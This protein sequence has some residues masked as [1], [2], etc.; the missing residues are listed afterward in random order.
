MFSVRLEGDT[1]LLLRRLKNLAEIDKKSINASI[2]EGMRES[3]LERF[4]ESRDP[5]GKRWKASIRA[6]TDGGKTLVQTAQLRN[7]IRTKSDASG[8]AVGT[9]VKHAATHQFGDPNR[10]IRARNGKALR[11]KIGDRWISKKKVRVNIP[12][13]PFLG[14]SQDDQREMKTILEEVIGG[15]N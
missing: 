13:R 3:T 8:F 7:S 10:T 12:A 11:F 1:R 15:D 4:R 5:E 9:N 2:S 14:F 6:A